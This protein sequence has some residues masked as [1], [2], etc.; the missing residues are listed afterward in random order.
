MAKKTVYE[1][2]TERMIEKLKEGVIPWRKTWVNGMAVSWKTQKPYR[3]V[4]QFLLEPGEYA[5]FKQI[6]E[7]GGKVKK[8]SKGQI[9]VFWSWIEKE[10]KDSG[11]IEKFP[12]LRYYKVFE[13][14]TQCE[15][16]ESKRPVIENTQEDDNFE[17]DAVSVC[18]SL[19]E[20]YMGRPVISFISGRAS[21]NKALDV[22]TCPPMK[23]FTN[24]SEFYSTLFHELVHSTGHE[25]RLNRKDLTASALFGDENYSKEELTAEMGAAMLCAIAGVDTEDSFENSAAYIQSWLKALQDDSTMVVRAASQAQKAVDYIQGIKFQQ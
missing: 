2:V 16:L 14:N 25:D 12:L 4:N 20:G 3:G 9:V 24:I 15:G 6:K 18:E 23:D 19:I 17:H 8:G 1:I 13:I 7:A 21:Y 22:V 11:E 10:N 5:T